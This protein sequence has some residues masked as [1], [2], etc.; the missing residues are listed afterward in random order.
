MR[1][2]DE[3]EVHGSV[4]GEAKEVWRLDLFADEFGLCGAR[5]RVGVRGDLG[6]A[7]EHP[8]GDPAGEVVVLAQA[9]VADAVPAPRVCMHARGEGRWHAC[10]RCEGGRVHVW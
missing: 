8:A 5:A 9:V 10:A 6:L 4:L 2:G 1:G 3:R 7:L